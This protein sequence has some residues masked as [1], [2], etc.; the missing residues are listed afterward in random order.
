[1]D[2]G[3]RRGVSI[4]AMDF[5]NEIPLDESQ[6]EAIAR[7]LFAV[8]SSDGIHPREAALIAAFYEEVGLGTSSLAELQRRTP[9]TDEELAG[10][11]R[12]DDERRLFI[13]SALLLAWADG[14]VSDAERA[15]IGRFAA[16]LSVD[17]DTVGKLEESVKDFLMSQLAHLQNVDAARAVAHKFES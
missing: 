17:Q 6:A 12:S 11:L 1:M 10:A 15:V 9:I 13:K 14:T 4:R 2:H 5:F 16:A 3:A 7:G 8:A